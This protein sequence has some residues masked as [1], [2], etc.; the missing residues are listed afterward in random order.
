MKLMLN[1][2]NYFLLSLIL[3]APRSIL[4][5]PTTKVINS[6]VESI[7]SKPNSKTE[8]SSY[9]KN[10]QNHWAK[11]FVQGLADR[12]LIS[13]SQIFLPEQKVTRA[14]LALIL[15]RAYPFQA[16]I[17]QA[18]DNFSASRPNEYVTRAQAMIAIATGLEIR[19]KPDSRNLLFSTY[20]DAINIPETAIGAIAAL[21]DKAIVVNY[22][23][24]R[25]LNPKAFI[26]K[27]ELSALIYQSL[28]F[29]KQ[30]PKV[31][32]SFAVNPANIRSGLA[33]NLGDVNTKEIITHLK[34]NL[35]RREVVAYQGQKKLKTYPLGVGRAG[36]ET[37][38]GTYR[39][40]QIIR[41]P[42]WKNPFT[43]DV[44]KAGDRDNPL[45]GFWI[46]F[47]TNGKD[48]SGFHGTAQRE[49]VGKASSHGCLRMYK[50][51]IKA[52]FSRVTF[53]TVV[54]V[55]R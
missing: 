9:L 5:M 24:V 44:I 25:Q 13:K 16:L 19:A 31:S 15:D 52:I 49:S 39:V 42:D 7:D 32:S 47:W 54:E 17:K 45:N 3:I 23:D 1:F 40:A 2:V 35:R 27:A 41:N 37:P 21:T 22:P 36:W 55:S 28:V 18:G 30:L 4:A 38:S 10:I 33:A 46:G 14:E 8:A 48:W 43:G 29:T 20:A 6:S 26:T 34:V 50:E 53:E 12:N 11:I 51:D